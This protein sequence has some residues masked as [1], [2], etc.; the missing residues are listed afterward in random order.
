MRLMIQDRMVIRKKNKFI[1]L[2]SP[3]GQPVLVKPLIFKRFNGMSMLWLKQFLQPMIM[4]AM[5]IFPI[6]N[7]K[8][9][10]R[11]SHLLTLSLFSML[12]S[13]IEEENFIAIKYGGFFF[14]FFFFSRD[15]MI[16]KSEMRSYFL[17]AKYHDL[18]GEF[19][20]DFHETTYFKPTFCVHCTGLLWG[21]IKQGWKCKGKLLIRSFL[22]IFQ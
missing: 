18:K 20:H 15:G 7:S 12:I 22:L 9:S 14:F 17:R 3:I 8:K 13:K 16:S 5:V 6:L 2:F 19:K 1:V 10:L 11:I 4:I 21:L